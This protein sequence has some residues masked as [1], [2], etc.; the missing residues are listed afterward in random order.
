MPFICRHN[1]AL[2]I[3]RSRAN[4]QT[5]LARCTAGGS[6]VASTPWSP[7]ITPPMCTQSRLGSGAWHR[8]NISRKWSMPQRPP[9]EV[10]EHEHACR[11][12]KWW[13]A[14]IISRIDFLGTWRLCLQ[15]RVLAGTV[16]LNTAQLRV[17]PVRLPGTAPGAA[18]LCIGNTISCN[19][20]LWPQLGCPGLL[21]KLLTQ[22][23]LAAK[24]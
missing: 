22:I 19:V 7:Q 16:L 10:W 9:L 8:A 3:R 12:L 2:R 5:P 17:V 11:R 14:L 15:A 21:A 18:R 24:P 4:L 13:R 20:M 6:L 23:A 1:T